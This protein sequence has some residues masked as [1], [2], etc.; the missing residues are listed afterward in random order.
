MLYQSIPSKPPGIQWANVIIAKRTPEMKRSNRR[1]NSDKLSTFCQNPLTVQWTLP[2]VG[3]SGRS[4]SSE[5][6]G[7]LPPNP[8]A[9]T[10]FACHSRTA[11]NSWCA[12]RSFP[13]PHFQCGDCIGLG[14]PGTRAGANRTRNILCR[15]PSG[16]QC[17]T[18]GVHEGL[19][20]WGFLMHK[21]MFEI[22]EMG[23]ELLFMQ[24]K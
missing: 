10:H 4:W 17:S 15:P 5:W 9:A 22:F 8:T 7:I 23:I 11:T 24:K 21:R 16:K 19:N 2:P 3:M 18:F 20:F 14:R 13:S 1:Q 6:S 12:L